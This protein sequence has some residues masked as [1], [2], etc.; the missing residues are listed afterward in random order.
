MSDSP[1]PGGAATSIPGIAVTIDEKVVHVVSE[2]P[3]TVISSAMV[4]GGFARTRNIVNMRVDD[5]GL[6]SRPE[7]DLRAFASRLGIKEPFVGLMTAARTEHARLAETASGGLTVAAVVSVGL[8]N[9]ICA[10][11]SAPA[12]TS[13]GT[14]NALVLIDAALTPAAMVN[15]VI[16]TSEAKTLVLASLDV[17]TDDG[18]PAGGTSTDAVVV[19]CT[20]HGAQLE[21]AG[22]G[23]TVGWLIARSVRQAIEQIGREQIARDGGRRNGW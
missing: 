1:V 15:A 19:A 11:L 8:S 17:R 9:R 14:I 10:G 16:T 4:G 5:V 3:L 18:L 13:P 2:R 22:P 21:Y 7:D 6:D 23:T 20:G 12:Q